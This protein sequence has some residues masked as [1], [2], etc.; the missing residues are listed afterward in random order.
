[1]F[2]QFLKH[3]KVKLTENRPNDVWYDMTLRELRNG[4]VRFYQVNDFLTGDWVFK[5]CKD[6]ELGKIMVK[7][8]KCPAGVRFSQLEGNSMLF[9]KSTNGD[10]LYDLISLTNLEAGDKLKR[11]VVASLD[12]IPA[13]IKENYQIATYEEATGKKA[14]GKNFVTLSRP[15]D[16]KMMVTLFVLERAWGLSHDSPDQKF[17]EKEH[18]SQK[19]KPVKNEVDTGQ[20]FLCPVCG[21]KHRLIHVETEKSVKHVLKKLQD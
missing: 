1:V 17:N 5:L 3:I 14:P 6:T 11:S 18:A 21:K 15:D 19:P 16:E 12:E 20:T 10:M 8:V 9:Q 13:V 4:E 2:L 7:A